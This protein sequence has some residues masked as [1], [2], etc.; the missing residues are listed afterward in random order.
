MQD[1]ST[2]VSIEGLEATLVSE[3]MEVLHKELSSKLDKAT[4]ECLEELEFVLG[5]VGIPVESAMDRD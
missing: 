2:V 5:V 4:E 3:A 1:E